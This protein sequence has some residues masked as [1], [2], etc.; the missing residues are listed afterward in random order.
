[1]NNKKIQAVVDKRTNDWISNETKKQ[2]DDWFIGGSQGRKPT[3]SYTSS[4]ILADYVK[5]Q[6][7]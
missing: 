3:I 5:R 4:K 2:L 1:M 7:L 6:R